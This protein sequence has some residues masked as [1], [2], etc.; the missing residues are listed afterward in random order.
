MFIAALLTQAK[1][2]KR[3]RWPSMDKC[4]KK[5]YTYAVGYY[6]AVTKTEILPFA[7]TWMDLNDRM[8]SETRQ[9]E[10]DKYHMISLICGI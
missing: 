4:T 1:M 5:M 6:S 9:S 2:Q 8:L 10:K 3:R 7:T